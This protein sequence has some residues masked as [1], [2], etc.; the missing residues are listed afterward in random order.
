LYICPSSGE[1]T[2]DLVDADSLPCYSLDIIPCVITGK[3]DPAAVFV[4][5]ITFDRD[6]H[7]S[8][9]ESFYYS[10]ADTHPSEGSNVSIS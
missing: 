7:L 3:A 1:I 10:R 2:S 8:Q 5:I 4:K 9:G 6:C